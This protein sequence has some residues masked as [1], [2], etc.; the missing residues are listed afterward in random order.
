MRGF[1]PPRPTAPPRCTE[2]GGHNIVKHLEPRLSIVGSPAYVG[3]SPCGRTSKR[4][5]AG[6]DSGGCRRSWR[7]GCRLRPSTTISTPEEHCPPVQAASRST[8][9]LPPN[10]PSQ[11]VIQLA[12]DTGA[13]S[14]EGTN[15]QNDR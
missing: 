8:V 15:V 11:F 12:P 10:Q 3:T 4:S 6:V 7:P 13:G 1:Y 9:S 2:V 5:C 14:C